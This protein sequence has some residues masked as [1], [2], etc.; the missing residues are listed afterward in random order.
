MMSE[1]IQIG[2]KIFN[3]AHIVEVGF[4]YGSVWLTTTE[5]DP[6]DTSDMPGGYYLWSAEAGAQLWEQLQ[7][8]LAPTVIQ[9]SA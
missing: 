6:Q 8:Y 3:K 1:F 9:I 4:R 7:H 5:Y 2:D